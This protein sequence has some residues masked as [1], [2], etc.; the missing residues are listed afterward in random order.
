M[1]E[2][3]ASMGGDTSAD[4][5]TAGDGPTVGP[6][7]LSLEMVDGPLEEASLRRIDA[8]WRAANYLA[9]AQIYLMA[10]PLLAEPLIAEHVKP[11]L[12]GHFGTVPGLNLVWAHANRLI[13]ERDLD[14]VFVA[15]PGHGG[16]GP[17]A[18][19][20]LEGTYSE[21]YSD[22]TR[23]AEGM[24]AFFRQFSFPGGV[25]SHCAPE[26]PGSFHEGGELGYSLLH[27]CGAVLDNPE[28][29]AF[30]VI[31]DGEAETGALATSWHA[32]KFLRP[33]RDGAVLPILHLN[34]YKIANPTILA[35]I[36]DDDLTSMFRGLGYEPHVVA[37]DDLATVHQALAEVFDDCLDRIG[38]I[39]EAATTATPEAGWRWPMVI[40]RTPK[41]WTC[42]PVVDGAQV[43]GTFRAHQVPL[44]NAR[45]DD[46]HRAVL[47]AWLRSYRPEEL[48]DD[49]GTP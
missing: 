42:P 13:I 19:A 24:A 39:R 22:I 31:G 25:P 26:T 46:R 43:E 9:V 27:A 6:P 4:A 8:W 28:L 14:A 49:D 12:P 38:G 44:P 15:G 5:D 16:P 45:T 36:A 10:N 33:G 37:G 30:C 18:C 17:N 7:P 29:V 34:E 3:L 2:R 23:D 1:T 41:G 48:F 11:R 47:E 32:P 35:R 21:R 20:W 40:L